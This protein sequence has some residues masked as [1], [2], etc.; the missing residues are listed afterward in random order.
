[1]RD[2]YHNNSNRMDQESI[3][4]HYITR[5]I[6]VI[7]ILFTVDGYAGY[8]R[9]KHNEFVGIQK[10]LV[11]AGFKE[12]N[13]VL[14]NPSVSARDGKLSAE[15]IQEEMKKT[16][17]H[18]EYVKLPFYASEEDEASDKYSNKAKKDAIGL[19]DYI[20]QRQMKNKKSEDSLY[21]QY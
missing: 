19:D 5:I 18:V 14:E 8:K 17:F 16:Q 15:K 21:H 10:E 4:N 7:V 12:S 13:L 20:N 6:L 2:S 1:M 9:K 3:L 11:E